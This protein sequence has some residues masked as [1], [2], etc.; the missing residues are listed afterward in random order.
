[1]DAMEIA[2]LA[3][4]VAVVLIALLLCICSQEKNIRNALGRPVNSPSRLHRR[5]PVRTRRTGH[6]NGN[7]NIF[8]V[9]VD[10][11]RPENQP[12]PEYKWEDLPPSYEEAVM[13]SQR[14]DSMIPQI[15]QQS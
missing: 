10:D 12:P 6:A 15:T 7:A 13:A 11:D 8:V 5:R 2:M 1:M 3:I 4:V 14:Q 9:S